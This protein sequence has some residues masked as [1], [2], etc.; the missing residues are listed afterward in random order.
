MKNLFRDTLISGSIFFSSQ[1][2]PF[3]PT[4]HGVAPITHDLCPKKMM[5][6]D[7]HYVVYYTI[8]ICGQGVA[9][10]L[11]FWHVIRK[12]KKNE[13]WSWGP[14]NG[15]PCICGCLFHPFILIIIIDFILNWFKIQPG[16]SKL[17]ANYDLSKKKLHI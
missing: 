6:S 11:I 13:R 15:K 14:I 10:L 1:S 16:Y 5:K 4:G 9:N 17:S 7:E 8:L 2:Q 12:I 3:L